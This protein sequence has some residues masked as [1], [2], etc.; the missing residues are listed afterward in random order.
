MPRKVIAWEEQPLGRIADRALATR[1]GVSKDT[2]R[3]ARV[4]KRIPPSRPYV[5]GVYLELILKHTGRYPVSTHELKQR[6]L[7][8]FGSYPERSFYRVLR[9]LRVKNILTSDNRRISLPT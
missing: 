4:R 5:R 8:D 3:K 1:L 2:V 6:I 9:A 7:D